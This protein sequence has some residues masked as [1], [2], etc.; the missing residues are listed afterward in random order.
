MKKSTERT[1]ELLLSTAA[2]GVVIFEVIRARS[3]K[4]AG[5]A[6]PASIASQSGAAIGYPSIL[7]SAA[8]FYNPGQTGNATGFPTVTSNS[9]TPSLLPANIAALVTALA[10]GAGNGDAPAPAGS[11][12][13]GGDFNLSFTS[14]RGPGA[15]ASVIVS[16]APAQP[17]SHSN[18]GCSTCNQVTL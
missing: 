7:P 2:I 16:T 17:A 8:P 9:G 12:W 5:T 3:S 14:P 4:P 13:R 18:C 10:S 6:V 1:L 11:S 15:P